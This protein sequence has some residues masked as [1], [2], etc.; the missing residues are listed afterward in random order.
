MICHY[1]ICISSGF[2]YKPDVHELELLID[3]I[4]TL[5]EPP[6]FHPLKDRAFA[7]PNYVIERAKEELKYSVL[8]LVDDSNNSGDDFF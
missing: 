1:G 8:Q 5:E 7:D 4:R 2:C 6:T 3:N